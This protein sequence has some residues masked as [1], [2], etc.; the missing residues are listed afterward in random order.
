[1]NI[2]H[3][4]SIIQALQLFANDC[5]AKIQQAYSYFVAKIFRKH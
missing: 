5:T 1:M 2:E 4:H 3:I